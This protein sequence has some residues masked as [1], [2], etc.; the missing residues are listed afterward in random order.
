MQRITTFFR[1]RRFLRNVI[2]VYGGIKIYDAVKQHN[3][4]FK[5]FSGHRHRPGETVLDL[6]LDRISIR[7][8]DSQTFFNSREEIRLRQLISTIESASDD[9]RVTGLIVRGITG[10]QG[11]GLAEITELRDAISSFSKAWGGKQTMIHVPEGLGGVGNGTVPLYFASGFDSIHVQPTSAMTIPGLSV[12]SLFFKKLLDTLGVKTKKV[13]RKEFKTAANAF[14]EEKF[15]EP[16]KEMTERLLDAIM[17]QLVKGISEG[18]GISEEKVREA[19]DVGIM[20]PKQA[21]E[22]GLI[23]E[24]FYRDELPVEMRKRLKTAIEQRQDH[25]EKAEKEWEDAMDELRKSWSQEKGW[26][27]IWNDGALLQILEATNDWD[28]PVLVSMVFAGAE[29]ADGSIETLQKSLPIELRALKAHLEWLNTRPWEENVDK[30]SKSFL[31]QEYNVNFVSAIFEA[32]RQLVKMAINTL[33]EFPNLVKRYEQASRENQSKEQGRIIRWCRSM[34]TTKALLARMVGTL[35][36]NSKEQSVVA[37]SVQPEQEELLSSS[38]PRLFL[39]DEWLSPIEE[40]NDVQVLDPESVEDA[41]K[42]EQSEPKWD[43]ADTMRLRYLRFTDYADQLDAEKQAMTSRRRSR[44]IFTRKDLRMVHEIWPGIMNRQ[45]LNSLHRLHRPN[46]LM[47]PW[48]ITTTQSNVVALITVQGPIT[49]EGADVTRAAIRR[50][51]KDPQVSAIV[52]RVESPGGS[53][54]ASDLI[55]R[56]IAVADK[57]VVAS[58]GNVCASGGYYI[59]APCDRVIASDMT[60]TGSIGVILTSLN[61]A[62]LFEKLGITADSCEQG[63]FA[64]YFGVLGTINE[65]SEEFQGKIDKMIDK[66]YADFLEVVANGRGLT[67]KEVDRIA[68]GRVWAGADAVALGLVDEIGG[69]DTAVKAAVELANLP[70]DAGVKLID[71]P[72]IGMQLSDAAHRNGLMPSSLNEEGDEDAPRSKGAGWIPYDPQGID[73]GKDDSEDSKD[74][75]SPKQN[76]RVPLFNNYTSFSHFILDNLFRGMDTLSMNTTLPPRALA[77][78]QGLVE[79]LMSSMMETYP[80]KVIKEELTKLR[81]ISGKPAA[82]ASEYRFGE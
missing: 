50:A 35:A 15:T 25:R 6:D 34:W 16:E 56:A 30:R 55:S 42:E 80:E 26:E 17:K 39:I 70:P 8:G 20:D 33:E 59:S 21:I 22:F 47:T 77:L 74:S 75:N 60:I 1:K 68:R 52:L 64:E 9:P 65:W 37:G 18:R 69:L 43:M 38:N 51:D 3:I 5:T 27:K 45:D 67:I 78:C 81:A 29:T 19:I 24:A 44:S 12:G 11:M 63:R 53:A 31:A 14:T 57:P 79:L 49:D 7:S 61:A 41:E 10:L 62:G 32:E 66:S 48:R 73:D 76:L 23:D 28:Y 36:L 4:L 40:S 71:Y 2:L 13:A 58:M 72:T 82:I 54:T 46:F